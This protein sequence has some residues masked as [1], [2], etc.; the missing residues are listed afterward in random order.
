MYIDSAASGV[1][2]MESLQGNAVAK[3]VTDLVKSG[4]KIAQDVLEEEE[5][6]K[7]EGA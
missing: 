5:E 1:G 2:E 4:A 3:T 7:E 6:E